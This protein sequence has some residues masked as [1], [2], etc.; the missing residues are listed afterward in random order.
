MKKITTYF[1]SAILLV[2]LFGG[3]M[4]AFAASDDFFGRGSRAGAGFDQGFFQGGPRGAGFDGEFFAGGPGR[5]HG[6]G[7]G[8]EVT[9]VGD[10][11]LTVQNPQGDSIT[12]NVSSDTPVRLVESQS[13][14]S[15]SDIKVGSHIRVRGQRNEDGSV[16]AQAIMVAPEGD[17]AG[18]GLTAVVGKTISV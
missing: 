8:G 15:L 3:A 11:T 10:N 1:I 14:G 2:G 6:P 16:N 12:V 4:M 5:G 17:Q 13:E 7:A 18:G 9:A